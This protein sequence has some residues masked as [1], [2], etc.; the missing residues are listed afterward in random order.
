V[1]Q[2]ERLLDLLEQAP[3]LPEHEAKKRAGEARGRPGMEDK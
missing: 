3:T 2:D 1:N